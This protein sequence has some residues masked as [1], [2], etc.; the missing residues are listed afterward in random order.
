MEYMLNGNL[1]AFLVE[2]DTTEIQRLRWVQEAAEGVQLLHDADVLHC[3]IN[4]KN[5]LLDAR[6]GLKIADFGGSSLEGSKPSAWNGTRFS[7]PD[8]YWRDPLTVQDDLF[9]LGTIIYFIMTR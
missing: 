3:D 8:K 1:Q 4:P 7:L 6:L 5:F 9:A 2:R